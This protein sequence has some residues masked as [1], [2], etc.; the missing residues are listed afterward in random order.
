MA[1]GWAGGEVGL[2]Q[3]V[4]VRQQKQPLLHPPAKKLDLALFILPDKLQKVLPACEKEG[5]L[6]LLARTLQ[7]CR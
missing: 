6:H 7:G 2:R 1:G 3:F 4:E 5:P